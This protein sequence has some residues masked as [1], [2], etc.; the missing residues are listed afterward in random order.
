MTRIALLAA[1]LLI[2]VACSEP[3]AL[4]DPSDAKPSDGNLVGLCYTGTT[5]TREK[6]AAL[7]LE[8][9]PEGT[10]RVE[11]WDH[12]TFLNSCPISRKNRVTYRC[13]PY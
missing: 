3:P 10:A 13:L 9:C 11:V 6:L 5:T 4:T 8:M 12:D 1:P 7:A 2:L